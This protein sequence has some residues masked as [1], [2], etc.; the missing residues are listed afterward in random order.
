MNCRKHLDFEQIYYFIR[1]LLC[2][3]LNQEFFAF[4]HESAVEFFGGSKRR[5]PQW[6]TQNF[7]MGRI[8]LL[9]L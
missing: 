1:P 3:D 6:R 7:I 5:I 2:T 8:W 4:G 9:S